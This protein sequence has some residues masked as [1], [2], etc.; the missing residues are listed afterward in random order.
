MEKKL[1]KKFWSALL[2]FSLVGQVAWVVENMYFNVFIYKMF[3]ATPADISL[4]V[5]ASAIS[6]TLTT[7]LVGALSDRI[8]KRKLFIVSGYI[9][10]GVSILS[11]SLI[12]LDVIN[13]LF[14]TVANA[15]SVGTSLVILM[16][17]VMTF[18]GSSANDAAFNAWLTDKTEAKSRG[19][20]E[21][22][23][24]M[25][26]LIAILAVFGGFLSFNLDLAESWTRIFLLIGAVVILIGILGIF[27]I[28][29]APVTPEK[30]S[31]FGTVLYGFRP[32]TAKENP[33]LYLFLLL[34]ILFN[35]SIQI[36]MPYLIIYY[37]VS[38]AMTDYVIV[39]APAIVVASVITALWGRV[40]DKRGFRF[41]AVFSLLSLILGYLL[42]FWTR[43]KLPVFIGSCFMMSGYLSGM[44]VFG[45]VIRDQTPKGKAGRLQGIRI[46]SQVLLPGVIGPMI[47]RAVLQNAD[48]VVGSDGL[49]SFV[50]SAD[51]FL[52]ALVPILLLLFAV[53]F[54]FRAKKPRT[55]ALSTPFRASEIPYSEE[56]PNP[57]MKREHI[58]LLN[59]EWELTVQKKRGDD[60]CYR[61]LVPFPPESALSEVGRVTKKG[62]TLV[63]SRVFSDSFPDAYRRILHFGA[64][65]QAARVFVNRR[66]VGSHTGGYT[67]FS[68]DITDALLPGE[69]TLRVEVTDPL[70]ST[71]PYGKQRHM[72]GGMWYTPVS[73]IWQSVYLE[74]VP[75]VHIKSLRITPTLRSVTLHV[76]GGEPE[77]TL[78]LDGKSYCFT[79]DSF[80]L[81]LEKPQLWTPES[82]YL[83]DFTLTCGEDR[84]ASYFALR[85]I[86]VTDVHG[87]PVLTLNQKPYFF[88]GLLD[89]GYYPD[90]IYTPA[91]PEGYKNDILTM[92]SL[93]FNMLRK[94]IKTEPPLF[95]YY[96]DKY[97]MAVFQDMVNCGKY[98]FLYD[99]ALPTLGLRKLPKRQPR[100]VF[101]AFI[102]SAEELQE[103]LRNHPSVLY[104]TIY[105]EGW[106]QSRESEAYRRLKARDGSRIY[107]TTS[108][109]FGE[110]ESDV[111]SEHVYFK[112][113]D[114][115]LSPNRPTVLS[116]FGGYS[117]NTEGHVF[118][119]DRVYGYKICK[120][121]HALSSALCTLYL[122]EVLPL[123]REGLSAAVLTQLSDVEDET[124]GILTYDRSVTKP[125]EE[126]MRAVAKQ[127]ML[128]FE[129]FLKE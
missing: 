21:G 101:D 32:K 59:G 35:I 99:T 125:D 55:V 33:A 19:A 121:R 109:W 113:L 47:G 123:V 78:T 108:G 128:G 77:K 94:H 9:L 42:L 30:G 57:Q 75:P 1:T 50:P 15:A 62:E 96:C 118:N 36:F 6:A 74:A 92:K 82:P 83:Y 106:G 53:L 31:Y 11:F 76:T 45:A 105:N 28:E 56:H 49:V 16:D 129:A 18:F 119:L 26:P 64:V 122:T 17:A 3:H 98:S 34:F 90:G 22:L 112:K 14:P 12:R 79:G 80:T 81:S 25:M 111:K 72:R 7:V 107:D 37:E 13:A 117:C 46:F 102:R 95:Y 40:Y 44:A 29:D 73:G 5:A 100:A 114:F 39:M 66:L 68:F 63:Y 58:L 41:S 84:L 60:E 103:A 124:N 97:G 67:P 38:L 71:L 89:Q 20:A 91:S 27:L 61:I 70:D 48:T 4:M 52:A 126:A 110:H 127:L 2:L 87:K 104:Y 23:N 10:W 43:S 116:E 24:A 8:G 120:T 93:G 54:F 85:E 115:P 86:G 69:N 51:I 65:D 88:H